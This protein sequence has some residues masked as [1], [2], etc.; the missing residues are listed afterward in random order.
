MPVTAF[1][2]RCF[3]TPT[4]GGTGNFVVSA[5]I[6]GY[7]VPGDAGSVDGTTY[8]YFAESASKTQWEFG[9]T[10]G[11]S[12]GT[13]WTRVVVGSSNGGL[14]GAVVNFTS[15]PN[16]CVGGYQ[17]DIPSI[18][19]P[20]MDAIGSWDLSTYSASP[21]PVVANAN[22]TGGMSSA[23]LTRA[24]RRQF[25]GP[26]TG[27]SLWQRVGGGLTVHDNSATA[28]DGSN[29]A[30]TV[31]STGAW[32]I[33]PNS[34][35]S[36][37][38]GAYTI[39]INAKNTSGT[40]QGF[41]FSGDNGTTP[42]PQTVP[43][44][45]AWHR[46]SQTITTSSSGPLSNWMIASTSLG[47]GTPVNM[48]ICDFEL[49]AGSTD[50]G[51]TTHSPSGH[52][53]FGYIGSTPTPTPIAGGLDLTSGA[54]GFAQFPSTTSFSGITVM[55]TVKK[56]ATGAGSGYQSIFGAMDSATWQ[57]LAFLLDP[58]SAGPS[59]TFSYFNSAGIAAG[60]QN[61]GVS[62]TQWEPSGQGWHMITMRYDGA[63]LTY[64]LDDIQI[65]SYQQTIGA[66]NLFDLG[67][68]FIFNLSLTTTLYQISQVRMWNKAISDSKLRLAWSVLQGNPPG[69]ITFPPVRLLVTEGDS[70]TAATV[71]SPRP[72]YAA[73]Y[74]TGGGGVSPASPQVYSF[75][76][77]VPGS[78]LANIQA[79]QPTMN[80][81]IP[82]NKAGRKFIMSVLDGTNDLLSGTSLVPGW[83]TSYAAYL[84]QQRAAGWY[85]VL[86]TI[87]PS[88]ASSGF[89][90][91]RN[92][93]NTSLRTWVGVHC[94][95]LCDFAADPTMGPDSACLD[96]T[97]Y[98]AA[99]Q[100]HP[101]A[102]GQQ[103][104]A[105]VYAPVINAI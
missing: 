105:A 81:I 97:L 43:A 38:A 31:V 44:D 57:K 96:S 90:A 47:G 50:L 19:T 7:M 1:L 55:A 67:V 68:A 99:D 46:F 14:G 26:G 91:A 87:L 62:G 25:T 53:F 10:S 93:A 21:S 33:A 103:K 16:V 60:Y 49:Y 78:T 24:P 52:M 45:S 75:S 92:L 84:D 95:A 5:A 102:L 12:N 8:N 100:T 4:A 86:C 39:A 63:N 51:A 70:I 74:V 104:L 11:S 35:T 66:E 76:F 42:F 37:P 17:A 32:F 71:P 82:P 40:S 22:A 13:V 58:V 80:Q 65:M 9:T 48:Q 41:S 61:T 27:I 36:L 77:A 30:S 28:P 73:V 72:S 23:N 6:T 56:V 69:G 94:D 83:L 15:P 18:P 59:G 98:E 79:R 2:N 64:W 54:V 34:G 89:N 29:D 85:V 101:T 3:F 88:N 20:F